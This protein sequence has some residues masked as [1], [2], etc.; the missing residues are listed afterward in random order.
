MAFF[1]DVQQLTSAASLGFSVIVCSL[2][3]LLF[4]SSTVTDF[5]P[6]AVEKHGLYCRD[7]WDKK[8][9]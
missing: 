5:H 2:F 1:M 4:V 7:V 8:A 6:R 9:R 3:I